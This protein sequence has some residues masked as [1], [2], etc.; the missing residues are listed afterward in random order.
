MSATVTTSSFSLPPSLRR[1]QCNRCVFRDNNNRQQ[2]VSSSGR[3]LQKSSV[4][5]SSSLEGDKTIVIIGGTGRV[6]SS[7]ANAIQKAL[8]ESSPSSKIVLASRNKASFEETVSRYPGLRSK[9]TT[10]REVDV[11]DIQSIESAIKGADLVINTAGPFQTV[12]T[13][14][15]LEA[16]INLSVPNYLDVCDDGSYAKNAKSLDT[17]AK[18]S[19]VTAIT[20]GGIYPGC[21]L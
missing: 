19:K 18:A 8:S 7:S 5:V 3:R 9:T 15:I 21:L 12:K 16:C 2:L 4:S 1:Y 6:G 10:F 20:S 11:S 14:N 17:K 13:C